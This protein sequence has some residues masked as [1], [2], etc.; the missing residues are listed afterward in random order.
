MSKVIIVTEAAFTAM[1][2][3]FVLSSYSAAAEVKNDT[4][5]IEV[6]ASVAPL[7]TS[8]TLGAKFVLVPAGTFMMGSS[9]GKKNETQHQVTISKPFYIQTTEVTQGQWKKVMGSNP[10]FFKD[11]G[12]NCPVEQVSWDDVQEFIRKI[13]SIEGGNK[14]RLPTEAEWEYA[15]RSGGKIEVYS[16]GDIVDS[17]AWYAGNSGG[18]TH[19]VGQKKPND[20]GIYDMSGNVMEWC[21]D[22]NGSYPSGHVIDP[23]GPSSGSSRLIRGGGWYSRTGICRLVHRNGNWP[24]GMHY[25]IGFRVLKMQ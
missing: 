10:S 11:C 21:Q 16:S 24:D 8:P 14:Y 17:V 23:V 25:G 12:D 22:W 5:Q 9:S 6:Y 15:A 18:K 3:L 19:P 13:N 20:L 7:F 4:R 2:L 1:I